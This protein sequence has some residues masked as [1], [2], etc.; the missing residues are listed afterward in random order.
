[1]ELHFRAWSVLVAIVAGYAMY[2]VVTH[3]IVENAD[4]HGPSIV[5]FAFV[6]GGFVQAFLLG[7]WTAL[8]PGLLR[9][10]LPLTVVAAVLAVCAS[11]APAF[12]REG[13]DPL[14]GAIAGIVTGI[15]LPSFVLA[16]LLGVIFRWWTRQAIRWKLNKSVAKAANPFQ[17]SIRYLLGL[18]ALCALVLAMVAP[19]LR[20]M[21]LPPDSWAEVL[22]RF[23]ISAAVIFAIGLPTLVIPWAILT[24]QPRERLIAIGAGFWILW[25]PTIIGLF[26]YFVRD[27]EVWPALLAAQFG[28]AMLATSTT[29]LLYAADYRL[30]RDANPTTGEPLPSYAP[31]ASY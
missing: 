4:S 6:G 1:M 11:A 21:E 20:T 23:V 19:F 25:T 9:V 28:A 15:A 2:N 12:W 8:G 16:M 26:A 13:P 22:L 5:M 17:F 3:F 24:I 7:L 10:R 29:I 30:V 18:T 31:Q 14:A 27:S